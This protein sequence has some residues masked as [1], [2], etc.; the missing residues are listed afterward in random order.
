MPG[1][2]RIPASLRNSL[3]AKKASS[4]TQLLSLNIDL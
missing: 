4:S 3:L 2:S 1:S